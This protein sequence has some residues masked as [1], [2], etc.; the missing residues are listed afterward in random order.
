L[1]GVFGYDY[2]N[3]SLR[4]NI[5]RDLNIFPESISTREIARLRG[6]P[7]HRQLSENYF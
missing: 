5:S 2:P 6:Y 7:Q 1:P 3:K 4:S